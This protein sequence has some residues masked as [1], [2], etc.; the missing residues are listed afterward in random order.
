MPAYIQTDIHCCLCWCI[1]SFLAAVAAAGCPFFCRLHCWEWQRWGQSTNL[2]SCVC[3]KGPTHL[4]TNTHAYVCSVLRVLAALFFLQTTLNGRQPSSHAH[5][6][7]C[8]C[9]YYLS[10]VVVRQTPKRKTTTKIQ[11]QTKLCND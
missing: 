6:H 10:S 4:H 7:T 5:T 2:V 8:S 1:S 11:I 9:T 3:V